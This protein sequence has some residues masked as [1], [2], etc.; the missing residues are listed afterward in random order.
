VLG[1]AQG[2]LPMGLYNYGR[3]LLLGAVL[4]AVV[5]LVRGPGGLRVLLAPLARWRVTPGWYVFTA[6]WAV[7]L[8]LA[9]LAGQ[10]ALRGGWPAEIAPGLGTLLSPSVAMS[11]FVGALVG[12]IVW[13]SYAIGRLG[14]R[15][16]LLPACLI[17][18]TVWTGWWV[19]MALLNIGVIPDLPLAALWLNMMGVAAVCGFVYA[20]TRSGLLVLVLQLGVNSALVVFPVV[21]TTGGVATYWAFSV[22]YLAAALALHALWPPRRDP[23]SRAQGETPASA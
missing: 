16:G 15:H 17:V 2:L 8:C 23:G 3:F 4:L 22:A 11:I 9:F 18:G 7:T 21:P 13:V 10:A 20:H 19:P 6:F 5:G 1:I 12:E 14:P